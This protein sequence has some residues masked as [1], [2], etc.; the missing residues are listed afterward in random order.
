MNKIKELLAKIK[1]FFAKA[2]PCIPMNKAIALGIRYIPVACVC[3]LTLHVML[4]LF[5]VHEPI[6]VGISVA[7]ILL[8]LILLSFRF[9]FCKL[10]RAMIIYMAIMTLCI[11]IQRANLFGAA[12][13]VARVIMLIIGV[14]LIIIAAFKLKDD[15]CGE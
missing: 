10:H 5:G 1:G 14:A 15:E 11:C 2:K 7:L 12:L 13:T 6:S 8:L 3:L 4:L 9:H